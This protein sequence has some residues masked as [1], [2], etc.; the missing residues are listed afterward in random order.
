MEKTEKAKLNFYDEGTG[1]RIDIR[2]EDISGGI[3]LVKNAQSVV[4]RDME[5]DPI[6]KKETLDS[7]FRLWYFLTKIRAGLKSR[8][9]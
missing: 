1:K 9:H 8:G 4:A 7:Y 6:V 2:D 5:M 3:D